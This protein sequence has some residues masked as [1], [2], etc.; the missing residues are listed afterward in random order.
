MMK[1]GQKN[2]S[3]FSMLEVVFVIV[4]LGIVSS[5]GAEIIAKIYDSYILQRAQH[6]ASVKTELAATQ[7]ANRLSYAIPGTIFRRSTDAPNVTEEITDVLQQDQDTYY[8]LQWVGYDA[9]SFGA[10]DGVGADA[11]LPG[12]SGFCDLDASGGTTLTTP[13]SN[14]ELADTI[15]KNLSKV[16]GATQR[17]LTDASI[18]FAG[19]EN[20]ESNITGFDDGASTF[21]LGVTPSKKV[22]HYKLAWTS[23][24]LEVDNA[25]D[26][27]LH[28]NF[29]PS[30]ATDITNTTSVR[31]LRNIT[32]FKF[33]GDGKTIR[34]KICQSEKISDDF[35]ITSCKEKAVF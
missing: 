31:L 10:H 8:L 18:Y 11:I 22:E 14:L 32:T 3:A 28:Y 24:A 7:I 23:Y 15:I 1:N 21:T 30:P 13:G 19:Y 29:E 6:R 35:N 5:I 9:D 26:L 25:G 33:R 2:R 27:W 12:W 34:F 17:T 16:G 4:I 20:N